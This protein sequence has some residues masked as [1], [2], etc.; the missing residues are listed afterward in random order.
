LSAIQQRKRGEMMKE[1]KW[2][3]LHES[4]WF[5]NLRVTVRDNLIPPD[6]VDRLVG[7][8]GYALKEVVRG[9][10]A[11]HLKTTHDV[12][13]NRTRV[14]IGY[15][16]TK[17]RSDDPDFAEAERKIKQYICEGTPLRKTNRAGEG[18]KGT[19]LVEG[20]EGVTP[21]QIIVEAR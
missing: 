9:E 11:D 17:T 5:Y 4:D 2:T 8:V 20:L 14:H 18:T 21:E 1:A 10:E 19:R 15:D 16:S 6:E 12:L 13:R 3:P 7:C